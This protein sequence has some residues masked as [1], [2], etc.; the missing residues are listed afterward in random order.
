MFEHTFV[1]TGVEARKPAA[2]A[3]SFAA[4]TAAIGGLLLIQLM[5][6]ELLPMA[7]R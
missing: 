7:H 3:T 2:L 1:N 5:R 4:Q 6:P